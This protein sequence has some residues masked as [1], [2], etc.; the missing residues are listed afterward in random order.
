MAEPADDLAAQILWAWRSH[1]SIQLGLIAGVPNKGFAAVPLGSRGRTVAE[2]LVHCWRVR[3]GWLHYFETGKR[4][5]NGD[6]AHID[7]PN[8]VALRKAYVESG[9]R[10]ENHLARA[11][12]GEAKIR[13]HG[14]SPVRWLAY[15]VSHE[16]HHRGSI[17]LAL[18]QNGT[19]L[20]DE[21][22]MGGLWG[23]WI[24]GR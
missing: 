10:V 15:L 20:P 13:M 6:A 5:S 19:S 21:V 3:L 1:N 24:H 11:L 9:K 2:Q 7:K 12:R 23:T 14:K 16:A 22:A 17:A 4:P 8:R 18:K